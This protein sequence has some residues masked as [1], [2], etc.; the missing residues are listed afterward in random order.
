MDLCLPDRAAAQ[1][2]QD[3][4]GIPMV[5]RSITT[6]ERGERS[7]TPWQLEALV[8]VLG[9]RQ[10]EARKL[11]AR[12]AKTRASMAKSDEMRERFA[13]VTWDTWDQHRHLW[14]KPIPKTWLSRSMSLGRHVIVRP[15]LTLRTTHT[16]HALLIAQRTV[17]NTDEAA[18]AQAA[19]VEAIKARKYPMPVVPLP[20][21]EMVRSATVQLALTGY[22]LRRWRG[23]SGGLTLA[24]WVRVHLWDHLHVS[25]KGNTAATA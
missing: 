4:M 1:A 9:L 12:W 3:G 10:H 8:Y 13:Q 6:F 17:L 18:L 16:E 11:V 5:M 2:I 21:G 24:Q 14:A 25:P 7:A 22:Q 15:V 19:A 23:V 20:E